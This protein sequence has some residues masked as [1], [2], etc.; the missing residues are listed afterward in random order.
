MATDEQRSAR[1][2]AAHRLNELLSSL[3]DVKDDSKRHALIHDQ[4]ADA[5][6]D[7]CTIDRGRN[8]FTHAQVEALIE[9][10]FH[11][12]YVVDP[13][14]KP[15][16]GRWKRWRREFSEAAI[17]VKVGIIAAIITA[18]VGVITIG[19]FVYHEGSL[20]MPHDTTP[21]PVS[22]QTQTPPTTPTPPAQ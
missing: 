7:I 1:I 16:K 15:I 22:T 6:N 8:P 4:I 2:K 17:G 11:I 14:N 13:R 20:L 5:I 3:G 18:T 19:S 12:A 9:I 10:G 21:I